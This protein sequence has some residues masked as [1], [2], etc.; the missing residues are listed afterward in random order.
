[1]IEMKDFC[2]DNV[3][4]YL[5]W[6]ESCKGCSSSTRN[7][8]LAVMRSFATFVKFERPELLSMHAGTFPAVQER[9]IG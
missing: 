9:T 7:Q 8:R 1:M 3:S 5:D 2:R 4:E 6:Q